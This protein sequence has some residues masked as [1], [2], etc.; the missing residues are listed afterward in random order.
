MLEDV[1]SHG[2]SEPGA[3]RVRGS[4]RWKGIVQ[5]GAFDR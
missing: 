5:A 1:E 3:K 2:M 4:I